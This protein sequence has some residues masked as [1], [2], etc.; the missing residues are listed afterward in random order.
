MIILID[1]LLEHPIPENASDGAA[2]LHA[3]GIDISMGIE[4]EECDN[5]IPQYTKL[6]NSKL[7][8]MSRKHFR[9]HG[10]VCV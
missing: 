6:V 9:Q 3:A 5:L 8:V 4:Q 1:I 7:Q 2:T 10:K